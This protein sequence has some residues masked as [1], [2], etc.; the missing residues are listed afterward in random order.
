MQ[1]EVVILGHHKI[2]PIPEGYWESWYYV[3]ES[4]FAVAA[5]APPGPGATPT[6][7]WR[8]SSTASTGPRPSRRSRSRHLRRRLP[9]ADSPCA[10]GDAGVPVPRSRLR[11]RPRSSGGRTAST[12][13]SSRSKKSATWDD[14]ETLEQGGI[15]VQSHGVH[16]RAFDLPFAEE[17]EAEILESKREIESRL[18]RPVELFSFP[19]G[20]NS[21]N[22]EGVE[23][24]PPSATATGAR[25]STAAIRSGS[26]S[27]TVT[28]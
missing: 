8:P 17:Q 1:P 14:L 24:I 22:P 25:S 15:A 27:P 18:G 16:H 23:E 26:P 3:P 6:S 7:T 19:Y 20:D 28:G 4:T 21:K 13:T 10:A 12:S 11:S 5:A 2:G 9:I